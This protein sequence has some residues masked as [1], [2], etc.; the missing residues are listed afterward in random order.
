MIRRTPLHD[1][2]VELGATLV[3]F[4]GWSMP[5]RY[6][7]DLAEHHAVRQRAGMF[8]LSHMGE[9]EVFGPDAASGL[10]HALTGGLSAIDV[11]RAKYSL[12]CDDEGGVMDDVIVYRRDDERFY[13]VANAANAET[14]VAALADRLAHLDAEVIDRSPETALIAVQGPASVQVLTNVGVSVD[15]LD[16]LRPSRGI[17]IEVAGHQAFLARTGYTGEDGFELYVA[18]DAATPLWW[19]LTEAGGSVE[20]APAGL[21]CRDTLRLEAGMPLYGQELSRERT[22]IEAGL[23]RVVDLDTDFVG[24]DALKGIDDQGTDVRLVGLVGE[25]RRAPRTGYAVQTPSGDTVGEVTSGAL[26]PTL[27]VPIAMAYVSTGWSQ[28]DTELTVDVRGK[29]HEVKVTT[30]PFYRRPR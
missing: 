21:A 22:P 30:L 20:M 18:N 14:V 25:G 1:V 3:D 9:I 17:D 28:P 12:L 23:G 15:T 11:G 19:A 8:D 26:S 16:Q 29:P 24:R 13:V 10:D 27:G 2:H 7:S 4:A 5:V 6:D